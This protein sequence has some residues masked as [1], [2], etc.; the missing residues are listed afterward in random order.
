MEGSCS[1]QT[2]LALK[3]A[4]SPPLPTKVEC[5]TQTRIRP[6]SD[7]FWKSL[8]N[9]F[10]NV[11]ITRMCQEDWSRMYRLYRSF[12]L[13]HYFRSFSLDHNSINLISTQ[14]MRYTYMHPWSYRASGFINVI[15]YDCM[16]LGVFS[17]SYDNP[18][19]NCILYY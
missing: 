2:I 5:S 12:T 11:L 14:E 19:Y 3:I 16:N 18:Y 13:V 15:S 8:C 1:S 9:T 4:G 6:S 7:P 17:V 10:R